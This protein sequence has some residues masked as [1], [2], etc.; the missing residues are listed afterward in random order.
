MKLTREQIDALVTQLAGVAALVAPQQTATIAVVRGL[1][2]VA[3][4]LFAVV[5]RVRDDDPEAWAVV[6]ADFN[7]AYER[8]RKSVETQNP[9]PAP[10]G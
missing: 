10:A 7:D 9:P 8:F 3:N 4:E 1:I 2:D 6:Q 5:Q